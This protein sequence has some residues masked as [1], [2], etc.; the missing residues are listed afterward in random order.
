MPSN[1]RSTSLKAQG[2]GLNK[3]TPSGYEDP[4][5]GAGGADVE[6]VVH[7]IIDDASR[8]GTQVFEVQWQQ[9]PGRDHQKI[10][11]SWE[12]VENIKGCDPQLVENHLLRQQQKAEAGALRASQKREERQ[13]A[14]A[15][16]NDAAHDE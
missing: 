16:A 14:A 9:L 3:R 1:K 8:F 7:N 6:F 2:L 10:E 5:C 4:Y 15:R 13:A 12:P 11:N